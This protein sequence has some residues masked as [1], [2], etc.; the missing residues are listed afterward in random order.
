MP[1]D[2]ILQTEAYEARP[3]LEVFLRLIFGRRALHVVR[4]PGMALLRILRRHIPNSMGATTHP[5]RNAAQSK[6]AST[7]KATWFLK[8]QQAGN[9]RLATL[10]AD[11]TGA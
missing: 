9:L 3:D 7:E 10:L 8:I 5:R 1:A 6:P 4:Q 2:R 11:Q